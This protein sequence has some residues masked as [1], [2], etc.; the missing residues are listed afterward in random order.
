M[1]TAIIAL[2]L[3]ATPDFDTEVLPVLTRSGCNAGACHGAAIG[4]GGFKLSLWGSDPAEDYDA[5]V[6]ELEGRRI[7]LAEPTRSLLLAKPT[8]QLE[9]G[10][11]VRLE[12]DGP[13]EQIIT[14]WIEAGARR[15]Q[16]RRMVGL[17]VTPKR[18]VIDPAASVKL[19]TVASFDDGTREDVTRW[20]IFSPNDS[21]AVRVDDSGEARVLR[22]GQNIVVV[23]YLDRV[24]AI[25]LLTP[26]SAVPVELCFEPRRNFIDEHVLQMLATLRLAVS[27]PADDAAFLRRAC[28]DLTGTLPAASEVREFVADTRP[29]KRDLLIERLLVS[30]SFTGFWTWRWATLFQFDSARMNAEGVAAFQAWLRE[31]ISTNARWDQM[32]LALLTAEGDS[33]SV[34]AANFTRASASPRDQAELVSQTLMGVRLRC[35]NCH[36]HPLDRWTQDDYHGLAAIFARLERG[37]M[38]KFGA[39][40]GV[41][42]PRTGGPAAPR[43]PGESMLPAGID[44]RKELA[45][46]LTSGDNRYFARAIVNRLWKAMFGRGLVEPVDDLRDTNPATHPALLDQLAA[47]FIEHGYDLRHTLRLIAQ[48]ATYARSSQTR[49]ENAADDRFYSHAWVRPLPVAVLLDAWSAVTGVPGQYGGLPNGSRAIALVDARLS[50]LSLDLLGRCPPG[51]DCTGDAGAAGDLAR[52]LHVINGGAL[53]DKLASQSGDLPK[54]LASGRTDVELVEEIYLRA[55]CRFP[56]DEERLYWQQQLS[57]ASPEFERR[58]RWEDLLWGLLSCREF[59]TNH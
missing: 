49:P 46:W 3:A 44:G 27:P 51:A 5:I 26:L 34:G 23:R 45:R 1:L 55:L 10:G 21:A 9:H 8:G 17:E 41:T 42:H 25:E 32:A 18:L 31:Q 20:T 4:R 48:S 35:A 38:V 40:G 43:I 57:G 19:K 15:L 33:F 6:H 13:G 50:S 11:D 16:R 36:N 58:E 22:Q 24:E 53:N 29:D 56:T 52:A 2:A 7:N 28:L 47:D 37:R 54:L 14:A 39:G 59:A 12:D 30:K